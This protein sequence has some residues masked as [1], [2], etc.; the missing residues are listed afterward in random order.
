[1]GT[2]KRPIIEAERVRVT[3]GAPRGQPEVVAIESLSFSVQAGDFVAVIGGSGAGKT[4]LLRSLTGFVRPSAGRLVVNGCDVARA[5]PGQL[6]GLRREV[7]MVA[8][9][10]NLVERASALDN[11]LIGR[12]GQ[13]GT[14][15]SLLGWFPRRDRRLASATLGELGLARRALQR[16]DRLSGGERQRV[17]IARALVQ[18]PRLVLADEP[19]ASLDISLARLVLDS[20]RRLNREHGV[21]VLVNL[22]DLDLAKAYAARILALRGGRLVL[23]GTPAQLTGALQQEIYHGAD[24]D[25]DTSEGRPPWRMA[26]A[27]D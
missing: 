13:V 17:A 11:V 8:Q 9:H 22:H 5:R 20:L 14:L 18:Q 19:A 15:P 23:D 16:A 24:P 12:L 6:H 21:T 25:A 10:F 26:E 4:T 3:Y 1:M 2:G 7:A 27:A